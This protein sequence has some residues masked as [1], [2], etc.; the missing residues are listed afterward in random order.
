MN[1]DSPLCEALR[2]QLCDPPPARLLCIGDGAL[3][4]ANACG[5]TAP[6]R[7][8]S[9]AQAASALPSPEGDAPVELAL[10]CGLTELQRAQAG[11]L[12]AALRDR[13]ARQ[14]MVLVD[15]PAGHWAHDDMIAY[16]LTRRFREARDGR[17]RALYEFAIAT[18]KTTPDWL[19]A[20]N[21]ANPQLWDKY[22]W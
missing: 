8:L 19:N 1:P 7:A 16:G 11:P 15:A 13:G 20:N 6:S 22:R 3:R 10:L 4:L 5:L 17:L 2:S 21:W 9:P 18:Y 14:L 12:I